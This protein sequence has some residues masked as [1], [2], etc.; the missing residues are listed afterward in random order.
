MN[1]RHDFTRGFS[2]FPTARWFGFFSLDV[3]T[4]GIGSVRFGSDDLLS[5]GSVVS[6]NPYGLIR[7]GSVRFGS[8]RFGS[9]RARL[10][11]VRYCTVRYGTVR[12]GT[13]RYG[14]VRCFPTK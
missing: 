10:G 4:I 13:V 9:L 14:T 8:V 3:A 6:F 1:S 7:F 12:Y 5:Y 11:T 2:R